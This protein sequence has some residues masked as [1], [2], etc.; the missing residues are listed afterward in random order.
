[1]AKN[2]SFGRHFFCM[3]IS[4]SLFLLSIYMTYKS[5]GYCVPIIILEFLTF[6]NILFSVFKKDYIYI[7]YGIEISSL[8]CFFISG[9]INSFILTSF[10]FIVI[11][12][13]T[14]NLNIKKDIE[15]YIYLFFVIISY[16]I[17]LVESKCFHLIYFVSFCIN[18]YIF[19]SKKNCLLAVFNLLLLFDYSYANMINFVIIIIAYLI[20]YI[21]N[22]K[23]IKNDFILQKNIDLHFLTLTTLFFHARGYDHLE[24][25]LLYI[26]FLP[27]K[28]NNYYLNCIYYIG[29]YFVINFIYIIFRNCIFSEN[30]DKERTLLTNTFYYIFNILSLFN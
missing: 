29:A 12:V 15:Y 25:L 21:R 4:M 9:G 27:I 28:A 30:F 1:M 17:L 10:I 3:A 14:T 20:L 13:N 6:M 22:K 24:I 16:C 5:F 7:L 23:N 8:F 2:D 11:S 18:H 26:S 19:I